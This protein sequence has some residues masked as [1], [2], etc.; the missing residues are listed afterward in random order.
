MPI[1]IKQRQWRDLPALV[2]WL[3]LEAGM[4]DKKN[5]YEGNVSVLQ[6]DCLPS[7]LA[8]APLHLPLL[9]VM[10]CKVNSVVYT[11][12]T[13]EES[14]R[15][16]LTWANDATKWT[17]SLAAE[18][19][20][21]LLRKLLNHHAAE[22]LLTMVPIEMARWV[23]E[24]RSMK[25]EWDDERIGPEGYMNCDWDRCLVALLKRTDL[26][27]AERMAI[28]KTY[29]TYNVQPHMLTLMFGHLG[30]TLKQQVEILQHMEPGQPTNASQVRFRGVIKILKAEIKEAEEVTV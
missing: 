5:R 25:Q 16:L 4:A 10:L 3:E 17:K 24:K 8:A 28:A 27:V 18:V 21:P 19:S 6:S 11:Y 14:K 15:Y 13:S 7:M 26:P 12:G 2:G 23:V 29:E 20:K 22:F 9:E 1:E 30:F